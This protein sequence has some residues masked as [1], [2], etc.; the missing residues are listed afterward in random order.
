MKKLKAISLTLL[1]YSML[2]TMPAMAD[3]FLGAKYH[4]GKNKVAFMSENTR[5]AGNVFLPPNYNKNESYPAIVVIT[6]ASGVKEQ[7]AAYMLKKWRKKA[8]LH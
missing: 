5:I 6:P 3:S 8:T 2:S 4:S 1:T 7:T